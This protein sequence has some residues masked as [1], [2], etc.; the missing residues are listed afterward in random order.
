MEE[1]LKE[2]I[3]N[4]IVQEMYALRNSAIG[5][6]LVFLSTSL[7]ISFM[8][9]GGFISK[10]IERGKKERYIIQFDVNNIFLDRKIHN[11]LMWEVFIFILNFLLICGMSI[12][13]DLTM[14]VGNSQASVAW[15][16][17]AIA[18]LMIGIDLAAKQNKIYIKRIFFLMGGGSIGI[19]T[20]LLLVNNAAMIM[21]LLGISCVILLVA[22][23]KII[24]ESK[25]YGM[26]SYRIVEILEIIRY[27]VLCGSNLLIW[28][29]TLYKE[30]INFES[31]YS[32]L[33]IIWWILLLVEY[34]LTI[35]KYRDARKTEIMIYTK[36]GCKVT[37]KK[38]AQYAGDKVQY[39]LLDG[40]RVL[41]D[42]DQIEK[43]TYENEYLDS[44]WKYK[45]LKQ[46]KEVTCTLK[47]GESLQ[48]HKYAII[49][50]LWVSLTRF[51]EKTKSV[52]I[53]QMKDIQKIV[54]QKVVRG[55][56][57]RCK[58]IRWF[59]ENMMLQRRKQKRI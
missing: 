8:D 51:K 15:F 50:D 52:Q 23:T 48:C 39:D 34:V 56:G 57:R 12:V 42:N 9:L 35:R 22:T 24:H 26:A 49:G 18:L 40:R 29:N 59:Y 58:W 37:K 38:I 2:W 1:L 19:I 28:T 20:V 16:L 11:V 43:I 32:N 27:I 36:E 14:R 17:M 3:G 13:C 31:F 25:R 7:G 41:I 6:F 30:K 10:I 33:I 55:N 54:M 4:Q 46:K 47:N 21:I 53:I 44:I 45:E 5:A